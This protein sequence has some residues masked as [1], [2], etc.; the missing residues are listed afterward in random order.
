MQTS[1]L[2][3]LIKREAPEWSS[4]EIRELI[5]DVQLIMYGKPLETQRVYDITTGLPDVLTTE[6]GT[7][8][9]EI[10]T[11]NSF[12]ADALFIEYV[13]STTGLETAY[14]YN[15]VREDQGKDIYSIPGVRGAAAKVCFKEDPGANDFYVRYFKKPSS[16]SMQYT[17]LSM[18]EHWHL[19]GVRVGVIGIIELVEHGTSR[20]WDTFLSDVIPNFQA[21]QNKTAGNFGRLIGSRGF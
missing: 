8:Q 11:S 2:I 20:N 4:E 12:T 1:S 3:A 16:V 15:D 19:M 14:N 18:P 7:Y 21:E 13:H 10:S 17:N 6:A 9:Y 5:S